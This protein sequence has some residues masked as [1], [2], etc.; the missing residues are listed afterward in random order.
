MQ[1]SLGRS[2]LGQG[3]VRLE[4][5][6]APIVRGLPARAAQIVED[7][8]SDR[9]EHAPD[10]EQLL[11]QRLARMVPVIVRLVDHLIEPRAHFVRLELSVLGDERRARDWPLAALLV[12][13]GAH[14][15]HQVLVLRARGRHE[16][17]ERHGRLRLLAHLG[18]IRIGRG[19]RR[20][21]LRPLFGLRVR[22]RRRRRRRPRRRIRRVEAHLGRRLGHALRRE[23]IEK[24]GAVKQLRTHVF[25]R[26][27][28]GSRQLRLRR[29]ARRVRVELGIV[30][31]GLARARDRLD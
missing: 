28:D 22:R 29:R 5:R 26:L 1:L 31:L 12:V 4:Q 6:A 25:G 17:L 13:L 16:L 21:R 19:R 18:L 3:R 27:E 9:V 15:D 8:R 30:G 24:E 23:H 10:D 2:V 7:A 11:A 14:G 20:R